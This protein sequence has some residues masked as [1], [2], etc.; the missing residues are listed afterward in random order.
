MPFTIKNGKL[1]L[2]AFLFIAFFVSLGFWQ[3]SRADQ[4]KTL[5]ASYA[6]RTQQAPL[7]S[8]DL[9]TGTDLRFYRVE[10]QGYFDNQH[11]LLLDNK[12]FHGRVG[13]EVYTPFKAIGLA[14]PILVDRGFVPLGKSRNSL[15]PIQAFSGPVTIKGLLTLPPA[16]VALGKIREPAPTSW[17]L[18]VQYIK[19]AELIPF[20][21]YPLFPYIVT[22]EPGE[23]AA[24]SIEWQVVIMPPEKHIGYAVQWFALALTLL[25]LFVVLNCRLVT[26]GK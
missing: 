5:L 21:G 20:L 16:Y 4:K 10:L 3:L 24:Y 7:H 2:L 25:I 6:N 11:T 1:A 19:G 17:P 14:E 15:P 12:T 18:R 13:Y 8:P 26:R 23:P 22:I 9:H